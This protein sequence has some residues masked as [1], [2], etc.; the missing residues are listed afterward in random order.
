MCFLSF[1][2]QYMILKVFFV[3][4]RMRSEPHLRDRKMKSPQGN[5]RSSTSTSKSAA[6]PSGRRPQQN[7]TKTPDD[8]TNSRATPTGTPVNSHK[9]KHS[10]TPEGHRNRGG[11]Q[12]PKAKRWHANPVENSSSSSPGSQRGDKP[13]SCSTTPS[14]LPSTTVKVSPLKS[15]SQPIAYAGAKFSDPPSPKVLPK[16]P[17][18]WMKKD[19]ENRDPLV[20]CSEMTNVLKC[21][22]KVQA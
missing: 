7:V 18:H 16:P 6:L 13:A 5:K 9:H 19:S 1:Y 8:H 3:H 2:C 12:S 11:S 14:K 22:L 4:F 20:T 10:G 21:M 17:T 15:I